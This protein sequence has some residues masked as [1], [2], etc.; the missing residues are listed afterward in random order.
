MFSEILKELREDSG[1]RQVDLANLLNT[2]RTTITEYERGINEPNFQILVRIADI[3]NVSTDYLLERTK[4]KQ[5]L[6]LLNS[7]NKDFLLK[8]YELANSYKI[9]KK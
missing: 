2:S 5:N 6:N 4:E 1:M 3:F 9:L 8:F 7:T